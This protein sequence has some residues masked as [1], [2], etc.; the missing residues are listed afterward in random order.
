MKNLVAKGMTSLVLATVVVFGLDAKPAEASMTSLSMGCGVGTETVSFGF[1]Q[2]S[3]GRVA[4]FA[5]SVNG[6]AWQWTPF[7]YTWQGHVWIWQGQW[8]ATNGG[9]ASFVT[10]GGGRTVVGYGFQSNTNGTW[11]TTPLGTCTTSS[12]FNDG[13]TYTY[14]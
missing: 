5:Y 1:P 6:G 11:E 8:V 14:R 7:Y 13:L 10:L 4:I 3:P 2:E 12:F 9:L